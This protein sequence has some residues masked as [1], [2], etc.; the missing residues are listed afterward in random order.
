MNNG[1]VP[2]VLL[3]AAVEPVELLIADCVP[4]ESESAERGRGTLAL[5]YAVDFGVAGSCR[6]FE[7]PDTFGDM[8]SA[9]KQAS[10]GLAS[11]R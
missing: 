11:T 1:L 4:E 8:A 7:D 9:C 10:S 6:W 3:P 2:D 5:T